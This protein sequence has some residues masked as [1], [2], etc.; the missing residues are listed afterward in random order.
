[1]GDQGGM[2][3]EAGDSSRMDLRSKGGRGRAG[4]CG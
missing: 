4:W 1:M 2:K 3:R